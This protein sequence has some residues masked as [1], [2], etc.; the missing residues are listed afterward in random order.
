[1]KSK[2][3]LRSFFALASSSLL[4]ISYSHAA[5]ITWDIT[6]GTVGAGNGTNTGGAG[7]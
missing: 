3:P 4:A 5:P 6:P 2:S 1:M 7:A